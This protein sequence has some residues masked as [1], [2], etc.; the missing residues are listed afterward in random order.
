MVP[1][2]TPC[3]I[4]PIVPIDA[5]IT[6]IASNLADPLTNGTNI[7]PSSVYCVTAGDTTS[8]PPGNSSWAT[9]R[10]WRVAIRWIS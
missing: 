6:T 5:G 4:R 1:S 8:S 10:A 2:D 9:S 3:A 7:D